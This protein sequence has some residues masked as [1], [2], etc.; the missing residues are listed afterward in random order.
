MVDIR[1]AR[2]DDAALIVE[3]VRALAEY[4]KSGERARMT[5]AD[6]AAAFFGANPRI[7]CDIA[8]AGGKP[9]GCAVW[10]YNFSTWEG[11][12]GIYLEDIFVVPEAR[13]TGAGVALMRHLAQ[14]CRDEGLRR[15]KWEVLDW[16]A[17][18]IAFYERLGARPS[19][20]WLSYSLSGSALMKLAES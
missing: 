14:R 20:E 17:P 7:W 8:E 5:E 15:L 13:G 2:P 18:S 4:E 12:H 11:R 9:V 1:P 3:F 19:T 6:V 16:N 10:Y